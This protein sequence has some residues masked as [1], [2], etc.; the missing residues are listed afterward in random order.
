MADNKKQEE[1]FQMTDPIVNREDYRIEWFDPSKLQN[2]DVN[3]SQYGDDSSAANYNNPSLWWWENTKYEWENTKNSQVAYNPNATIEWL[4]P[5]YKYGQAAQMANS[6]EANYIARRNDEIASALYNAWKTSIQDVSDFLNTQQGFY[7]S[8]ENERANT[9]NSIWKRLGQMVENNKEEEPTTP[10]QD[11]IDNMEEEMNKSTA[12]KIY[13]KVTAEGWDPKEWIETLEDDTSVFKSM[14]AA[15][16]QQ[17]KELEA[18]SDESIATAIV[19]NSMSGDSQSM[20]DLMQYDYEKY[21]RVKV[22][23]KKIRAQ[24]KV[25][26]MAKW[27]EDNS[28]VIDT[29]D[30]NTELT[31]YSVNN[32]TDTTSATQLLKS[33][34]SILESNDEAQSAKGLMQ[35]I[36]W[37]LAKL[38]NRLRNL[39]SEAN[40]VFK[41][42]VPDYLVRAYMANRQQEIQNNMQILED[43]YNAAYSR[44][45]N[46][47][48]Q[49]QWEKEY[50][51]KKEQLQ[52]QKDELDFKKYQADK[53]SSWTSYGSMR[54]ERNNNPTAMTTD[55]AKMMGLELGV[56]YEIWDS[57]IGEDWRTYYTAKFIWDPIEMAIKAFD[58]W[59]ANNVFANE[60]W[61]LWHWHLGISNKQWL[62]M[63]D[64]E[65]REVINK[66]LK[67]EWGNMANMAY[68]KATYWDDSKWTRWDGKVFDLTNSPIYNSLSQRDKIW[69]QALLNLQLSRADI[70]ARK[71]DYDSPSS[72]LDAV[73]QI[74]PD[75]TRDDIDQ[76]NKYINKWNS[77]LEWGWLDRAATAW[78]FAKQLYEFMDSIPDEEWEWIL[79]TVNEKLWVANIKDAAETEKKIWEQLWD[80]RITKLKELIDWLV[81]EY[82]GAMKWGNAS[83]SDQDII[84]NAGHFSLWFSK[85]QMKTAAK[86]AAEM[87]YDKTVT[88]AYG[89]RNVVMK[90]PDP[91]RIPSVTTWISWL[92]P[93]MSEFFSRDGTP[94]WGNAPTSWW[95]DILWQ[96]WL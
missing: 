61:V 89:Y 4:D 11:A 17:F 34:D 43:R 26:A 82:A 7:N 44:Y 2:A 1:L 10:N 29:T 45:Q 77:W 93:S 32:A 49:A 72:I 92:R 50:E 71:S 3:L 53:E 79:K 88:A 68:Y 33:I 52:L 84:N 38:K 94:I 27:E 24:M 69:V 21:Q 54:T 95:Q 73:V 80:T 12:W 28:S 13:G 86:T 18:M 14:N 76:A 41:G 63:T 46:E 40:Q 81:A 19:S 78:D 9:I 59:A 67:K 66:I 60:G 83:L 55:Y 8:N 85:N 75:W 35:S 30:V 15:R 23:E 91:I 57:F 70:L 47:V 42:D 37:D 6:A 51:L 36:E 62:A 96:N 90:K 64:G 58:T 5:D 16:L 56:D 31:T 22:A 65:K 87:V 39:K 25:D 48:Q 20:R 74:N